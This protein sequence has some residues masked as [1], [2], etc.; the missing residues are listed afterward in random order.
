MKK[1]LLILSFCVSVNAFAQDGYLY[2]SYGN[3]VRDAF[4]ECVHSGYY[5][6]TNGVAECDEDLKTSS[7][8]T[9]V[10]SATNN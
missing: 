2:D 1:L 8:K 5:D 4:N 9:G 7:Q 10:A 6:K 3:V